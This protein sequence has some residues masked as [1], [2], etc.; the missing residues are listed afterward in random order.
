MEKWETMRDLLGSERVS[1]E[2]DVHAENKA[3]NTCLVLVML[4]RLVL[5]GGAEIHL[6][7][8]SRRATHFIVV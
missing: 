7:F 1:G 4:A 3:G 5:H 2:V 6:L 8:A